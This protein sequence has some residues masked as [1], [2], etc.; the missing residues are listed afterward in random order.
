M[1]T[2]WDIYWITRLDS[3]VFVCAAIAIIGVAVACFVWMMGMDDWDG[4]A[5]KI[6]K[7][8]YKIIIVSVSTALT[9]GSFVPST[10]DAVAIYMIPKIV[11]NEQIQKLPDNAIKF[12]NQKMEQWINDM[13]EIKKK[14][15]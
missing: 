15:K 3:I 1:I 9:I 10:K 14:D 12:L 4:E 8:I 5:G 6:V 11:N 13:T 7:K 2:S